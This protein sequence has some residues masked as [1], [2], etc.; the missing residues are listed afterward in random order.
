MIKIDKLF[1]DKKSNTLIYILLVMGILLLVFG[2]GFKSDTR[3]KAD[4]LPDTRA[5]Q[6]ERILSEIK[7]VGQV[8]VMISQSTEKNESVFVTDKKKEGS[9]SCSVLI[10][11]EGGDDSR[12]REKIVRAASAALGV[13]PHKIE[14]FERKEQQ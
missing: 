13:E 4:V 6:A 5:A 10:V 9:S 8:R 1:G 7:G 11:A 12:V 3:E 14:V 2:S